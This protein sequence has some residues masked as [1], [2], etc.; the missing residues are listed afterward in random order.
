M[1]PD[2][3]EPQVRA[4]GPARLTLT[5]ANKLL[6]SFRSSARFAS[7]THLFECSMREC[8]HH[9]S[10][11]E[12]DSELALSISSLSLVLLLS[13]VVLLLSPPRLSPHP[14]SS[15]PRLEKPTYTHTLAPLTP[16]WHPH[17][18]TLLAP[19]WHPLGTGAVCIHVEP[20]LRGAAGQRRPHAPRVTRHGRRRR[21]GGAPDRRPEARSARRPPDPAALAPRGG[22]RA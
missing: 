12:S 14:P 10:P 19:S 20:Q 6:F 7:R 17:C 18:T 4:S 22:E 15:I 1:N 16:S 13:F 5:R 11:R 8:F 21:R 9:F 3:L 2:K